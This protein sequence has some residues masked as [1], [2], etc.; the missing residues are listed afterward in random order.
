MIS[1]LTKRSRPIAKATAELGVRRIKKGHT[2][3]CF[4]V[5]HN[6]RRPARSWRSQEGSFVGNGYL[7]EPCGKAQT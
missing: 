2:M 6:G 3:L 7:G 1:R 4:D 5:Y